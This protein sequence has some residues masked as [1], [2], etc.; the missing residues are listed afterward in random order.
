MAQKTDAYL[1]DVKSDRFQ[2]VG[3]CAREKERAVHA[4][5]GR[6]LIAYYNLFVFKTTS[7]CLF[8]ND[9]KTDVLQ[10]LGPRAREKERAVHAEVGRQRIVFYNLFVF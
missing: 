6:Q 8:I 3:F 9:V 7:Y 4:K 1:F 10:V 5:L 2:V